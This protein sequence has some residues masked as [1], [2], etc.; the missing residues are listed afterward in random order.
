MSN[1]DCSRD[2]LAKTYARKS[3][4]C[5]PQN[6]YGVDEIDAIITWVDGN[7]PKHVL[8][9]QSA[10]LG[11]PRLSLNAIPTSRSPTR[12][13]ASGELPYCISAIR[14]F[15]PWVRTIHVVTDDQIPDF[16]DERTRRRLGV[17]IVDHREI[18]R[19]YEWALP[20]FN[21]I[22]IG[23]AIYRVPG[24]AEK[25]IYFNDDVFLV[26]SVVPEDFFI[27]DKVVLRGRWVENKRLGSARLM[28][29]SLLNHV[30]S[31]FGVNRSMPM[32]AQ[33]NAAKIAG[34]VGRIP[35]APHVPHPVRKKTL[36]DFFSSNGH[37]FAGNIKYPFRDMR[38]FVTTPLANY[39]EI[40]RGTYVSRED[41]E[42]ELLCFNR[43][44][45]RAIRR[46]L[47]RMGSGKLTFLCIQAFDQ[48]SESDRSK[49]EALL[50]ALI[51]D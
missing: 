7:D 37:L 4:K 40:S 18:F 51:M 45:E 42:Y 16:L 25:Y 14:R 36:A 2:E 5:E 11:Q 47:D 43:D 44:S 30:Y 17:N 24:L 20:T 27:Q 12:F 23:T 46:K 41:K 39:L 35:A 33:F 38:Q 31:L 21:S 50:N 32:L 19:G 22:S 10:L 34:L 15:A 8:K 49:V 6:G 26:R 3:S 1:N 48:A 13:A 29:S 9:K 28:L